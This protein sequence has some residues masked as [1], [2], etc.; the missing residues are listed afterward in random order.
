MDI[1]T[2]AWRRNRFV[3]SKDTLEYLDCSYRC[4][5]YL[6]AAQIY[7]E[8][9][10]ALSRTLCSQD[11]KEQVAGHWGTIPGLNFL[12]THI[13]VLARQHKQKTQIV[14]GPG[15]G[16][17]AGSIQAYLDGT[18]ASVDK[19]FTRDAQGLT[20]FVRAYSKK[21]GLPSNFGPEIPGSLHP[22]GELGYV[23]SHAFGMALDSPDKL[24]V[25]V[26]G[27]GEMEE[28]ACA[29]SWQLARLMNPA[30]DGIVLP[31]LHMNGYELANPAQIARISNGER[32]AYFCGLGYTPYEFEVGFSDEDA[33]AMHE[34]FYT[35]LEDIYDEICQIKDFAQHQKRQGKTITR[36]KYPLIILRTP[37]GWG[38]PEY[39][40]Q[41]KMADSWR[42]HQ[43][44][45]LE[46]KTS[47]YER[48]ELQNWLAS[49]VPSDFFTPADELASSMYIQDSYALGEQQ[50][51]ETRTS[52]V[53]P[54][55]QAIYALDASLAKHTSSA[56]A[57][58]Q[59]TGEIL[60][61]NNACFRVFSP[62]E[63]ASNRFDTLLD[64]TN[65]QWNISTHEDD[66]NDQH[67]ASEGR[68]I[69]MLSEHQMMGL[70]EGYTLSGRAGMFVSYEAFAQVCASMV[71]QYI[72]W[73]E[74]SKTAATWRDPIASEQLVLTSH[75]WDQA[76]NGFT[77]QDPGFIDTLLNKVMTSHK[78]I[79]H[80]YMP[81]DAHMALAC[82]QEGL[83]AQ[84]CVNTY[85]V[86]KQELPA[87]FSDYHEAKCALS[88]QAACLAGFD[89]QDPD[90]VFGVIGDVLTHEVI[91]C[92]KKLKAQ[93][94]A[95]RVVG[96]FELSAFANAHT[97]QALARRLDE[98]FAVEHDIARLFVFHGY[99]ATAQKMLFP[100][101]WA[102]GM[103]IHGFEEQGATCTSEELLAM[104]HCDS[105]SLFIDA[106]RL[107]SIHKK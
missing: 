30:N 31:V 69:E 58:A 94:Y 44:P 46:A 56:R 90:I 72:K 77:H 33:C 38:C 17:P 19:R 95:V 71:Q 66:E 8:D 97:D 1:S 20:N 39:V 98:L 91:T 103:H 96:I 9:D 5:N 28:A 27:D 100:Y 60:Q 55:A 42:S 105:E 59:L 49:Y 32:S 50:K 41:E 14:V 75:V 11:I 26:V 34:R 40:H 7:L 88:K 87:V 80:I 76:R 22:G 35:F 63:L 78:D 16:G 62:D 99:V 70:L 47:D 21:D 107:L 67:L 82:M 6:S 74:V 92:A 101:A 10:I 24:I 85:V 15:H 86:S 81:S 29:S 65:K 12:Y 57:L 13:D 83:C 64:Y 84:D 37:K 68:I 43:M 45:F 73:L 106:S 3:P 79:V 23:L 102:Q 18:L 53:M 93:G 51:N 2:H 52:F 48:N 89:A 36:P 25:A 4:R 54:D 61:R 104:N